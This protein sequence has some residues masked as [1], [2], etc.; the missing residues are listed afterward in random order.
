[1]TD[2]TLAAPLQRIVEGA[3][4]APQWDMQADRLAAL[5]PAP[6]APGVRVKPLEWEVCALPRHSE[7]KWKAGPYIIH[8]I[9][10]FFLVYGWSDKFKHT[11][12]HLDDAK[13]AAQA[14]YEAR[15]LAALDTPD[16]GVVAELVE[17]H[18]ENAR[19]LSHIHNDLQ[20]RV[21]AAKLAALFE[22]LARSTAALA[23]IA[24]HLAPGD[25]LVERLLN[26]H[27]VLMLRAFGTASPDARTYDADGKPGLTVGEI[28]SPMSEAA[29]RIAALTATV[30][31]MDAAVAATVADV[32]EQRS[33]AEARMETAEAEAAT[34]RDRLAR[35]EEE[36]ESWKKAFA[37]Q[38]N[39]LQKVL[40]IP[41]VCAALT[42][43]G[44]NG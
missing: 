4:T 34:L 35:M 41:G 28:K 25:D 22:C 23:L 27:E 29:A 39:K 17:A 14:D 42:D 13:A 32:R 16:A 19:V 2:Y 31:E 5:P 15:I 36:S 40:H 26:E 20:G 30:A 8:Y 10:G 44:S 24:R 9:E 6:D 18:R 38:S 43:G 33:D 3:K 21:D 1:M 12:L 7:N 11:S 37:A